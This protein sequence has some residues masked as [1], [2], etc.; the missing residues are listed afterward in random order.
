MPIHGGTSTL[1]GLRQAPPQPDKNTVCSVSLCILVY[2]TT[3]INMFPACHFCTLHRLM[4]WEQASLWGLFSTTGTQVCR[5]HRGHPPPISLHQIRSAE[6]IG[7]GEQGTQETEMNTQNPNT[8]HSQ[9][10]HICAPQYM[11]CVISRIQVKSAP[12]HSKNSSSLPRP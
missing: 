2:R 6:R 8:S 11:G 12:P 9:N 10:T 3:Q 1:V 7:A 4:P 5:V